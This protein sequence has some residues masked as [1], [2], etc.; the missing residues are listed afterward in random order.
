MFLIYLFLK[1]C[2]FK[3]YENIKMKRGQFNLYVG[4]GGRR[5]WWLGING[6]ELVSFNSY[7]I[8]MNHQQRETQTTTRSTTNQTYK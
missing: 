1:Y 8:R 6:A 3:Y 4:L 7:K 2:R 5:N